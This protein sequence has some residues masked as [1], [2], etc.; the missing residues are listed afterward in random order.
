MAFPHSIAKGTCR[1]IQFFA[2]ISS[3]SSKDRGRMVTKL[4]LPWFVGQVSFRCRSPCYY[5]AY[6]FAASGYVPKDMP[7]LLNTLKGYNQE[8]TLR[9]KNY[10]L[11]L[12]SSKKS[13]RQMSEFMERTWK[14]SAIKR[15]RRSLEDAGLM[16]RS[17]EVTAS[18]GNW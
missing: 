4:I 7:R 1:R 9:K 17:S 2:T 13:V 12:A 8:I 11:T 14:K 6:A 3:C 10:H 5:L 16:P 18:S 15:K